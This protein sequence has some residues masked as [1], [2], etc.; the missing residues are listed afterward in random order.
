MAKYVVD[1]SI[2]TLVNSLVVSDKDNYD[3]TDIINLHNGIN[4]CMHLGAIDNEIADVIDN[5]IR[6]FNTQ[7]KQNNTP[8]EERKPIKIF[9]D[10]VGGDIMG[11]LT[12][13]DSIRQS[14]TPV[15]TINTGQAYSGGFFCFIAGHKR[16]CYPNASFLFHEG[17]TGTFADA[18]KF[19]N[20][21]DFYKK[22]L[23]RL[24]A[25]TLEFTN[26]TEEEYNE[27]QKD[28][29]WF[30]AEEALEKGICDEISKEL[31]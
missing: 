25:I 15:I 12:I 30:F 1:E 13:I 8:I 19:N 17:S 2:D 4:R 6:F 10:S 11:T 20:W 23:R 27:H 28:D 5:Y 7:D 18:N 21:A 22:I 31:I 16:I 14:D 9:I 26:I 3:F 29:W 24:R